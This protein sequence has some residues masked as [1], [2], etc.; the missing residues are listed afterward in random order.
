[1]LVDDAD[2]TFSGDTLTATKIAATTF[3]GDVTL[4]TK[5]GNAVQITTLGVGD[6][7]L[8]ITTN[9]ITLTGD[10]GANTLATITGGVTG[11]I[12]TILFVDGLITITD[13]DAH[14]ANT[15]DLSAA[16]TSAD[17]TILQLL[18]DG[19]SWYETSRSVN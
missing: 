5:M 2:L 17:D 9:F 11:Q 16:F 13:T 10:G 1:L 8:A 6:T 3:S 18:F 14:T 19:T 12:I 15:V 4:S 7:T